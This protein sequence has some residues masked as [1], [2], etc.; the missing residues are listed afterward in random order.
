[1]SPKE[2][3]QVKDLVDLIDQHLISTTQHSSFPATPGR[4]TQ[5]TMFVDWDGSGTPRVSYREQDTDTHTL[6]GK[7]SLADAA[8]GDVEGGERKVGHKHGEESHMRVDYDWECPPLPERKAGRTSV[9]RDRRESRGRERSRDSGYMSDS[10]PSR[11]SRTRTSMPAEHSSIP[12]G[13]VYTPGPPRYRNHVHPP[14]QPHQEPHLQSPLHTHSPTSMFIPPA[15]THHNP[16]RLSGF[17]PATHFQYEYNGSIMHLHRSPD[18]TYSPHSDYYEMP[19]TEYLECGGRVRVADEGQGK[20]K[21]KNSVVEFILKMFRMWDS[22]GILRRFSGKG[23]TSTGTETRQ[24]GERE[25][26]SLK[27]P[28]DSHHSHSHPHAQAP[29]P[30][31]TSDHTPASTPGASVSKPTGEPPI[32]KNHSQA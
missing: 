17:D 2:K 10:P 21:K 9:R 13:A 31:H 22:A 30:H 14:P 27:D 8:D 16:H 26:R 12:S 5:S 4:N 20:E 15:R 19:A 11:T 23:K 25:G 28:R 3:V 18:S 24:G 32:A 29:K 7:A 1:M 6:V